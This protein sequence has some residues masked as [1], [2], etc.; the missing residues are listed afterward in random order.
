MFGLGTQKREKNFLV[1]DYI[2]FGVAELLYT[3]NKK[4]KTQI[5]VSNR[6]TNDN[7]I[8]LNESQSKKIHFKKNC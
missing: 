6:L 7:E 8:T 4:R 3:Y 1:V 2:V 5:L